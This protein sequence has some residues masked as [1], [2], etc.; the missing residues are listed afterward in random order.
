MKSKLIPA[1]GRTVRDPITF[2]PL[3]PAG[4][5]K[6]MT[7]YWIRRR[8]DGDVSEISPDAP[9]AAAEKSAKP[10]KGTDEGK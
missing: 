7:S 5:Y 3:A 2:K 8:A 9:A 1:P 6:E 4:E 10:K